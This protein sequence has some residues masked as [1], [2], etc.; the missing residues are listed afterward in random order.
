VERQRGGVEG[1]KVSLVSIVWFPLQKMLIGYG[2][3]ANE[4]SR[5]VGGRKERVSQM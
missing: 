3:D 2:G 5:P 4:P 1:K